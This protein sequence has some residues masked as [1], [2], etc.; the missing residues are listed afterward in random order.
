MERRYDWAPGKFE[1]N[2]SHRLSEALYRV[3]LDGGCDDDLGS[4][5]GFGW[6]GIIRRVPQGIGYIVAEDSNGFFTYDR[7]PLAEANVAWGGIESEYQAWD[8]QLIDILIDSE[9]GMGL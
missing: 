9:E 8:A 4:T 7:M 5:D 1:A 2:P 3:S 6:Y